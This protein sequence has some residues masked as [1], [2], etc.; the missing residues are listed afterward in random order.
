MKPFSTYPEQIAKLK[1]RGLIIRNDIETTKILERENYYNIINGYKKIFLAKDSTGKNI[2][3]ETYIQYTTFEE[4]HSLFT[5]D[6]E[7]RNL[8][9]KYLLIFENTIKTRLAYRFSEKFKEP[10]AYLQL[11]NFS[12][13]EIDRVLGLIATISNVIKNKSSDKYANSIKHYLKKHGHVPLW[14]LVNN[15]TLGNI[16]NFYQ[17]LDESL[18]DTI[19]KDFSI[20][21]KKEYSSRLQIPKN[22]I[23]DILKISNLIRNICAHEERLYNFILDNPTRTSHNSRLLNIPQEKLIGNLFTMFSLLKLVLPKKDHIKLKRSINSLF[24]DYEKKFF[25]ITFEDILQIMG[26]NPD[27]NSY[28]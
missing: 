28:F 18:K 11:S 23:L 17:T 13:R 3:P 25:V 4:I 10:H 12:K 19:A 15:L 24:N 21:Y 26:F 7:L 1:S 27:W 14:V 22:S 16:S 20:Q 8:F 5:F 6:R 2:V 9:L